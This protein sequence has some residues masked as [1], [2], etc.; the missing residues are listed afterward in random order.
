M[1]CAGVS[2]AFRVGRAEWV[3]GGRRRLGGGGRGR[4]VAP[5]AGPRDGRRA[6]WRLYR[7]WPRAL[8]ADHHGTAQADHHVALA[9]RILHRR[10]VAGWTG[11]R[12]RQVR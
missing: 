5:V 8:D 1:I 9:A 4:V 2:G 12:R 7:H 6:V 10:R 11:V 3:G